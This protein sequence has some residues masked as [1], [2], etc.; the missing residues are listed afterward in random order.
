[1]K[2]YIVCAIAGCGRPPRE[3]QIGLI[4]PCERHEELWIAS[5]EKRR[6]ETP[7]NEADPRVAVLDFITR[8]GAEERNE[9]ERVDP[10]D[11]RQI[12]RG[13]HRVAAIGMQIDFRGF[14]MGMAKVF[15]KRSRILAALQ[16][17][18]GI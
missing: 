15:L 17:G 6:S 9:R 1:M 5:P 7:G 13:N 3:P 2:P 8:V 11:W 10:L 18:G 16:Q 14:Q 4:H 12:E